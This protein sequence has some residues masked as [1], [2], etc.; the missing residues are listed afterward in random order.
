MSCILGIS[1]TG[2]FMDLFNVRGA[3]IVEQRL[4]E[5]GSRSVVILVSAE[6]HNKIHCMHL[7]LQTLIYSNLTKTST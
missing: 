7:F 1:E 2:L 5:S 6:A 3:L 4:M